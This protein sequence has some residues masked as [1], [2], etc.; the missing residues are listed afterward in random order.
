MSC[1]I[2]IHH[3]LLLLLF[4]NEISVGQVIIDS[5]FMSASPG[6]SFSSSSNMAGQDADLLSWTGSSW[7]GGWPGANLTIPPPNNGVACRAVFMG[8]A[9]SWTTGGEGFGL[10]F[11]PA[12]VTGQTYTFNI[13]YVSH[14][15][16][17][18]GSFSPRFFTNSNGSITGAY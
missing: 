15:T 5:C 13:T 3:T 14:G 7:T 6:T 2:K 10:R 9:S 18:N 17:S 8:N 4:F 11:T 16:G 1:L 12:L